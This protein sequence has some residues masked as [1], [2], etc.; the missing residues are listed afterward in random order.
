MRWVTQGGL[1]EVG[2]ARWV[3]HE[4]DYARWVTQ[5]GSREVDHARWVT[6][7]T[8]HLVKLFTP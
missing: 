8:S 2:Y 3:M 6:R 5:G 7:D 1:C 4:V